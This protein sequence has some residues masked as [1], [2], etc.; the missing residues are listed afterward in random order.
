MKPLIHTLLIG[1]GQALPP[2]RLKELA[3]QADFIVAADGGADCALRAGV[4]PDVI[5]GDL[6]SVSPRAR[7]KLSS[8]QWIFVDNQNNTDL[9][10]AL[11]YLVKRNCKKC[12]LVGFNGGRVDFTLGNLL[13]L[14]PYAPEIELCAVGDGWKIYPLCKR[15]TF[16]TRH[17]A[18]VSLLPLT[19]CKGVTLTGLKFPLKNARLLPGTTRTLSNVAAKARFTVSLTHGTLL[20]YMEDFSL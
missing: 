14:V 2:H 12:T 5:I 10:K 11:D 13:A 7:K 18:R 4:V 9:Q 19:P 20:V 8:S 3:R 16:A 1:N 15:K 6:D 17:G